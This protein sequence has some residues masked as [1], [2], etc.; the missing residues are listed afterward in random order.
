MAEQTIIDRAAEEMNPGDSAPA[1]AYEVRSPQYDMFPHPRN[2][3]DD[4]SSLA[5][6]AAGG[7]DGGVASGRGAPAGGGGSSGLDWSGSWLND[8]RY[9]GSRTNGSVDTWAEFED[10]HGFRSRVGMNSMFLDSL[11]TSSADARSDAAGRRLFSSLVRAQRAYADNLSSTDPKKAGLAYADIDSMRQGFEEL[12]A[13]GWSSSDAARALSMAGSVFGGYSNAA[14]NAR[15]MKR[16]A[17]TRGIDATAAAGEFESYRRNF[18]GAYLSAYGVPQGASKDSVV[19]DNGNSDF[20]DVVGAL[21]GVED[22]Y[23]WQFNRATYVD[24]MKRV[25]K[26]AADLAVSGM[27]VA[28]VGADRVV[29]AAL[30]QNG[31]LR[32]GDPADNPVVKLQKLQ[33]MDR[34]LV[35][36]FPGA[37]GEDTVT[38]PF[39]TPDFGKDASAALADS[40]DFGLTRAVRQA[41]FDHRARLVRDG[42]DPDRDFG[43]DTMQLRSDIASSLRMFS[44]S[45]AG[46]EDSTFEALADAMIDS[47]ASRRAADV[48]EL[49][50]QVAQRIGGGQAEALGKW[51]RSLVAG[52][53]AGQRRLAETVM[54][55][56]ATLANTA[57]VSLRDPIVTT[58]VARLTNTLR[59]NFLD[60]RTVAGLEQLEAEATVAPPGLAPGEN[61]APAY[62]I[63]DDEIWKSI[64]KDVQPFLK[65]FEQAIHSRAVSAA[66]R[67]ALVADAKDNAG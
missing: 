55:F 19:V 59:R 37:E 30:M 44:T 15:Y 12:T 26:M 14:G 4:A 5:G 49:A 22:A 18:I 62:S 21:R 9:N 56:V 32:D 64:Q 67:A 3:F 46:V 48:T 40:Q 61:G 13:G 29:R 10:P 23:N 66:H 24:V 39:R 57:G 16:F 2:D 60:R 63:P 8:P 65:L 58:L 34:D 42:M 41:L 31:S 20:S 6:P 35:R 51:T 11:G 38:N 47:V 25:G 33:A 52:S 43:A 28:D 45:S 17:E 53:A 27:S 50:G 1:F 7:R 54:P 36:L